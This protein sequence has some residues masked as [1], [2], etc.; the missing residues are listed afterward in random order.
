MFTTKF[1]TVSG[2]AKPLETFCTRKATFDLLTAKDI[3]RTLRG[4]D[5]RSR[6]F[7]PNK[8]RLCDRA[9]FAQH[10]VRTRVAGIFASPRPVHAISAN[11]AA[12]SH[13]LSAKG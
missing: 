7:D 6:F 12:K 10:A 4:I 3:G 11:A 5:N 13:L 2:P 9:T 8:N 1:W